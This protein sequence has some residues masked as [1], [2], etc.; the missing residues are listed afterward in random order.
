MNAAA[1][2]TPAQQQLG[3]DDE[4]STTKQQQLFAPSKK[5]EM[6]FL[7][8]GNHTMETFAASASASSED[9]DPSLAGNHSSD[10]SAGRMSP[11]RSSSS[12]EMPAAA[13]AAASVESPAISAEE[14][15]RR[16]EQASIELARAMME[17]EAMASYAVSYE[18]SM[19]YLRNNQTEYSQEDLAALEAAVQEE[20]NAGEDNEVDVSGM[21][22]DMMLRLGEQIGDVKLERWAQKAQ[23][24]IDSL[25]T[26]TFDPAEKKESPNDCDVKCLIC[27]CHYD[28]GEK[29]RTLPCNHCFHTDCVDQWLLSKDF[30]P[31]CRTSLAD[32]GDDKKE[33]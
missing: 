32:D 27:Q 15:A 29:L 7:P 33:G 26:S 5:T 30:C 23:Q 2:E 17:E 16:D 6:S 14:Q 3:G 12:E 4:V 13:A 31:Y 20:E 28:K 24:V 9:R 25:P 21:S 1:P 8:T 11:L 22:Y 19:D 18:I 10:G